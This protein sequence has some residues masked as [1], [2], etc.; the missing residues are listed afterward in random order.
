MTNYLHALA[1]G[2][3]LG[4]YSIRRVLGAGAFGIT[5]LAWDSRRRVQVAIKEYLPVDV[6][7]RRPGQGSKVLPISNHQK[8]DFGW[9]LARFTSEAKILRRFSHANVVPVLRHFRTN[10]TGYIVM[11]YLDGSTLT[12]YLKDRGVLNEKELRTLLWPLI[13]GLSEIH[14][15]NYLHRDLKPSNIMINRDGSPVILDFGSARQALSARSQTITSLVTPGYAP[16]EQYTSSGNQGPWTDIYA[17][18]AVA[19]RALT[20]QAPMAAPE[21]LMEDE[22]AG[23]TAR[24][25]DTTPEFLNAIDRSL[26]IRSTDRPQTVA[27]WRRLLDQPPSLQRKAPLPTNTADAIEDTKSK[28]PLSRLSPVFAQAAKSFGVGFKL[29]RSWA[30]DI[31]ALCDRLLNRDYSILARVR[32]LHNKAERIFD[33]A[34]QMPGILW[35]RRSSMTPTAIACFAA[36]SA[37][38]A[39]LVW[40][41]PA[42]KEENFDIPPS[43]VDDTSHFRGKTASVPAGSSN[44]PVP[45]EGMNSTL[46]WARTFAGHRGNVEAL[47]FAPDGQMLATAANDGTARLWDVASGEQLMALSGHSDAVLAVSFFP[48]GKRVATAAS[49]ATARVWDVETGSTLTVLDGHGGPVNSVAASPDGDLL[50]TASDDQT[51]RLWRTRDGRQLATF[52][53]HNSHVEAVGFSTDGRRIVT[54]GYDKTIRFWDPDLGIHLATF[55]GADAVSTAEFSP[56]G[57]RVLATYHDGSTLVWRVNSGELLSTFEGGTAGKSSAVWSPDGTCIAMAS[58][59]AVLSLWSTSPPRLVATLKA[60]DLWVSATAFSPVGNYIAT[61]SGDNTAKLW[62]F[63]GVCA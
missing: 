15:A 17:L 31:P 28:L 41:P 59:D 53:G 20:G 49:D 60:H 61:A 40:A 3:Q 62:R 12:E 18:G 6:A 21:R 14:R 27:E 56:G 42:V 44:D 26:A 8:A 54:G 52:K 45:S 37:I 1:E 48:D 32:H 38:A 43:A 23:W 34:R 58:F 47:A 35:V 7:L 51:A 24:V 2:Y 4:D 11:E 19:Y 13:D 22:L 5:Y 46:T 30:S 63:S 25:Q 9:G 39:W 16:I 10:G 36:V 29:L 57:E 50:L 33:A 55:R